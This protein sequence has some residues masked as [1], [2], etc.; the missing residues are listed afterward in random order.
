M[1]LIIWWDLQFCWIILWSANSWFKYFYLVLTG[2]RFDNNQYLGAL[3]SLLKT[4]SGK[5]I[6][7]I[8]DTQS[9]GMAFSELS[10]LVYA[11]MKQYKRNIPENI[12]T[13]HNILLGSLAHLPRTTV[14]D[15]KESAYQK[16]QTF[17]ASHCFNRPHWIIVKFHW[18]SLIQNKSSV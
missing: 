12:Y 7:W 9:N 6:V 4:R 15:T 17:L 3:A 10:G 16:R 18:C 11:F 5:G 1:S 8:C 14:C 2:Q 13:T